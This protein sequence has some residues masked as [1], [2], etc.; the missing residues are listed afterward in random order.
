MHF[1]FRLQ[2][3]AKLFPFGL[4]WIEMI[5]EGRPIVLYLFLSE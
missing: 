1:E 3:G 4:G 2:G 5:G